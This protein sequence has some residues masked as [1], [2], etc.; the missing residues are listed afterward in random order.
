MSVSSCLVDGTGDR[1]REAGG[2]VVIA[3][4]RAEPWRVDHANRDGGARAVERGVG[5]QPSE[6][7]FD[8][9][10]DMLGTGGRDAE[11]VQDEALDL[12]VDGWR[13]GSVVHVPA[14]LP[15]P[16]SAS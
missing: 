1:P 11:V 3:G 8:Q 16:N 9:F 2:K 6:L 10:S 15:L 12:E 13:A 7:G 14:S 4:A 5:Q